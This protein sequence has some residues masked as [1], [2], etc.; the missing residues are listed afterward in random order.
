[1]VLKRT[2]SLVGGDVIHS[3][4]TLSMIYYLIS[5]NPDHGAIVIPIA[6]NVN[7][8]DSQFILKRA[9]LLKWNPE[10]I[11]SGLKIISMKMQHI[12]FSRFC[13]LPTHAF[14]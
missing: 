14:T 7:A 13:F 8:F 2:V 3:L 5:V 1:M 9:N 4:T 10:H 11:L 6:H 12:H